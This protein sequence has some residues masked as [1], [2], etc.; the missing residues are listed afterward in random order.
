GHVFPLAGKDFPESADELAE[1]IHGALG[2]VLE[3]PKNNVAVT[4]E[5]TFPSIR[6]LRINL[7]GASVSATGPPPKPQETRKREPGGAGQQLKVTGKP[8][9]YE[10][11]KLDVELKASGVKFD[12]GR[13]N[14]GQ[15]LLVLA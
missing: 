6:M 4:A 9:R 13:D 7:N 1:A 14:K 5:G 3:L 12:F 8:I 11:N 2:Q 15:P 10:K